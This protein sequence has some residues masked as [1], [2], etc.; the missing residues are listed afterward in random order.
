MRAL[1]VRS[2]FNETLYAFEQ[3]WGPDELLMKF[4]NLDFQI[5]YLGAAGAADVITARLDSGLRTLFYLWSPH[6]LHAKYNLSRIQ[7]PAF[8]PEAFEQGRSDYPTDILEKVAS[9]KLAA[10]APSVLQL[11]SRFRLDNT[12][13]ES[14]MA[15]ISPS[16]SIAGSACIW[17]RSPTNRQKWRVWIPTERCPKGH[18][19][20]DSEAENRC[21]ACPKGSAS[22][23]GRETQCTLCAAGRCTLASIRT[24]LSGVPFTQHVLLQA[25]SS[26]R[27]PS[28]AASAATA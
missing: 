26:P 17:I 4:L 5:V 25:R 1:A 23:G 7:L 3:D 15:Q 28:T 27:L 18:Y 13:Q 2:L 21:V 8:K 9:S 11:Y 6:T 19:L 12:A 10:I 14:M 20:D 22:A 24:D 16:V